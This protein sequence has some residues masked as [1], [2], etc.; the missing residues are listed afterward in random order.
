MPRF[1]LLLAALAL[2]AAAPLQS[3]SETLTATAR[4]VAPVRTTATAPRISMDV[5]KGGY[6]ELSAETPLAAKGE[7][8]VSVELSATEAADG[9]AGP[10]RVRDEEGKYRLAR[11]AAAPRGSGAEPT[12]VGGG[13]KASY[14]VGLPEEVG[15]AGEGVT[16]TYL[17]AVNG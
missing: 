8:I 5:R 7:V 2:S 4:L 14:R 16:V 9:E 17:V 10:T 6:A 3:Q 11:S 12:S 15:A 1:L 13:R